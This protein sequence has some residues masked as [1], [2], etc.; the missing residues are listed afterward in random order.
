MQGG[1]RHSLSYLKKE[2]LTK[3]ARICFREIML[4]LFPFSVHALKCT[5]N[6]QIPTLE[7][8]LSTPD[9]DETAARSGSQARS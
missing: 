6:N 4:R 1:L 7:L 2:I 9:P 3:A 5:R 8:F